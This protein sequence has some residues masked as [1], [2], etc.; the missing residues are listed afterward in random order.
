MVDTQENKTCLEAKK[1]TTNNNSN[2]RNFI[3]FQYLFILTIAVVGLGVYQINFTSYNQT[4]SDINEK[5]LSEQKEYIETFLKSLSKDTEQNFSSVFENQQKQIN[6][7][8]QQLN[9]ALN[10]NTKN[11]EKEEITNIIK[12]ANLQ[13]NIFNNQNKAITLLQYAKKLAES[14]SNNSEIVEIINNDINTII[15]I[16]AI[17]T[18]EILELMP[19]IL[20]ELSHNIKSNL[21]DKIEDKD[22]LNDINSDKI[23]NKSPKEQSLKNKLLSKL[24]NIV[25]IKKNNLPTKP[26]FDEYESNF[27]LLNLNVYFEALALSLLE[28]NKDVYELYLSKLENLITT[29]NLNN[30]KVLKQINTLKEV[31]FNQYTNI[32]LESL[33]Q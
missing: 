22:K 28:N 30:D 17:N 1:K 15:N 2:S 25:V 29:Y 32:K 4:K 7:L 21:Q 8:K 11:F 23:D 13:L 6:A 12:S 20:S 10:K 3:I 16:K 5:V 27:V 19:N 24:E 18:K 14:D 9:E 31:N 33:N 26:I